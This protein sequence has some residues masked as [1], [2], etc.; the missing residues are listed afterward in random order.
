[1]EHANFTLNIRKGVIFTMRELKYVMET[2]FFL[3]L[4]VSFIR[5]LCIHSGK[6]LFAID[7]RMNW[8]NHNHKTLRHLDQTVT[9]Y[10]I[11]SRDV[12]WD[13]II[14]HL[15]KKTK[16]YSKKILTLI[17]LL[18]VFYIYKIATPL[19]FKIQNKY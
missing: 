13:K 12:E 1:M 2:N 5:E 17:C 3:L 9:P 8:G 6:L 16:S 15:I 4:F 19:L 10:H 7:N 18:L 11:H 14:E